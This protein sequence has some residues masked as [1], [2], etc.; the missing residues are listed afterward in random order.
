MEMTTDIFY[1]I[2]PVLDSNA[3]FTDL[4]ETVYNIP[5]NKKR[6]LIPSMSDPRAFY[7]VDPGDCKGSCDDKDQGYQASF[8]MVA[9]NDSYQ[10]G[11]SNFT[12]TRKPTTQSMSKHG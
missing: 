6:R 5:S 12:K 10:W 7:V 11:G 9:S 3:Q 4:T 8:V 2:V 1:E